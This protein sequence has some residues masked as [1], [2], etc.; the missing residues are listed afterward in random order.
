VSP[1]AIIPRAIASEGFIVS[2]FRRESAGRRFLKS[3][4]AAAPD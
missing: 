3:F 1:S 4:L 2:A